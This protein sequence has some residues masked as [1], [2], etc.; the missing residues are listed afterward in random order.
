MTNTGGASCQHREAPPCLGLWNASS[1]L[2]A[3]HLSAPAQPS[4]TGSPSKAP[5]SKPAPTPTASPTPK[6]NNTPRPKGALCSTQTLA[7]NRPRRRISARPAPKPIGACRAT[8]FRRQRRRTTPRTELLTSCLPDRQSS[9][10]P[11]GVYDFNNAGLPHRTGVGL[12]GFKHFTAPAAANH[13]DR[14]K[15]VKPRL[16]SGV[17]RVPGE[18]GQ[19]VPAVV[20]R[21]SVMMCMTALRQ[22]YEVA[23]AE[24]SGATQ[25]D[26]PLP[27]ARSHPP[28]IR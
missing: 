20:E 23:Y 16:A 18:H 9:T 17:H 11:P 28:A 13:L 1:S 22:G 24:G 27:P 3:K 26:G 15:D 10:L 5:S 25:P 2:P 6:T 19:V 8:T 12:K 7:L 14:A 4:S 21:R